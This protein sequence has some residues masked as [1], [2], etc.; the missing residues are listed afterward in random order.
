MVGSFLTDLPVSQV[1]V[2]NG[3]RLT[4]PTTPIIQIFGID[5]RVLD[6]YIELHPPGVLQIVG[7]APNSSTVKSTQYDGTIN[8]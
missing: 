2:R 8:A 1:L 6:D 4:L 7:I 5:D 3:R